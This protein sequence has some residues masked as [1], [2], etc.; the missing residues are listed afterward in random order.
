VVW[1]VD[2]NVISEL[3]RQLPNVG[4]VGWAGRAGTVSIS[5]V[6]VEEVFYGLSWSPNSAVQHWFERF[7]LE[8]ADVLPVTANTA[9]WA[10][11]LR[12]TL[13][14]RGKVRSQADMLIAATAAVHGLTLATRNEHDF[15]NCGI[16]ILNPFT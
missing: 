9:R 4:V 16:K 7:F 2:T 6:T 11:D 10:G 8:R 1:L 5:A 3:T 12:G 14:S 15:E 13:R